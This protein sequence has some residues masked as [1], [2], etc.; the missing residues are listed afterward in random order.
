MDNGISNCVQDIINGLANLSAEIEKQQ[1][2]TDRRISAVEIQTFKNTE[3][4]REF[5]N[6][7]L[8]NLG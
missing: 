5:A 6:T 4:L 2:S 3:L 7:I 8:K 1:Q